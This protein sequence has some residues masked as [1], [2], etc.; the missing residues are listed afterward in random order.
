[1][2]SRG[3][4]PFTVRDNWHGPELKQLTKHLGRWGSTPKY[5]SGNFQWQVSEH[6]QIIGD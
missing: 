6:V 3:E 2:G 4:M 5:S 1:M